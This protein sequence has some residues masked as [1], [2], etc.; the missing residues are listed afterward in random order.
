M[1]KHSSN[2]AARTVAKDPSVTYR[3]GVNEWINSALTKGCTYMWLLC[4]G[5]SSLCNLIILCTVYK[6]IPRTGI[7]M[8]HISDVKP[9][10]YSFVGCA[11]VS[12]QKGTIKT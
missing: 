2:C 8:N 4:F 10:P 6:S 11:Y 1:I 9:N 12:C 7:R 3:R 5:A